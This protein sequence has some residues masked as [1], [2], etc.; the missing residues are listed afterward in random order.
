M[1][2]LK[3]RN[4]TPE[5]NSENV[6][7]NETIGLRHAIIRETSVVDEFYQEDVVPADDDMKA[8]AIVDPIHVLF[9]QQ[10]L[11]NLGAT[12]VKSF[13]D[14]LV[15]HSN[16]LSELRSKCSD[17]DLMKMIKSRHLQSPAEILHWCRYMQQNV[18]EFE[19]E[20]AKLVAEQQAKETTVD[21]VESETLKS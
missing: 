17:E 13:L 10:R 11:D 20:V 21:S 15:P 2:T 14:S 5:Q 7:F 6:K 12:A 9:N 1:K 16:D 4:I 8:V 18:K 19:S 3:R